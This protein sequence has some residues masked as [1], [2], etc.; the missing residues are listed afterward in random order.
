MSYR[1]EFMTFT[2]KQGMEAEAEEWIR[3]LTERQAECVQTLDRERMHIECI[4]K[5]FQNDRMCLSWFTVHGLAGERLR[6]S[7]HP[8]DK[9]HLEYWDK[10]IDKEVLPERYKHVVTF[11]PES[12][13]RALEARDQ[14]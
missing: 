6:G 13:R 10:C 8:I 11:L 9:L 2:I 7:P 14:P 12:I 1:T 3:I 5:S 4:F